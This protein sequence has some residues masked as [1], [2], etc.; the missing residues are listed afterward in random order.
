MKGD[1]KPQGTADERGEAEPLCITM[2]RRSR[3]AL[4]F[5]TVVAMLVEEDAG[6]PL[7]EQFDALRCLD[8]GTALR[9]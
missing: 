7:T 5:S 9:L 3:I 1:R 6:R 4:L 8:P 2:K